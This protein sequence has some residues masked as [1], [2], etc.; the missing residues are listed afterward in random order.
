MNSLQNYHHLSGFLRN[1][2]EQSPG[3]HL[4]IQTSIIPANFIILGMLSPFIYPYAPA[5]LCAIG[6]TPHPSHLFIHGPADV[7]PGWGIR[8][9]S[10]FIH[11]AAVHWLTRP[12][13][14][15]GRSHLFILS[16]ARPRFGSS[17]PAG[18]SFIHPSLD[19][20]HHPRGAPPVSIYL[21]IRGSEAARASGAGHTCS[22]YSFILA[23]HIIKQV[24]QVTYAKLIHPGAGKSARTLEIRRKVLW[25]EGLGYHDNISIIMITLTVIMIT[26]PLS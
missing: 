18:I 12:W 7:W 15:G 4:F 17:S 10:Q 22:I 21:F 2:H 19:S 24:E 3:L 13:P 20:L 8:W 25:G 9:Q 14:C 23:T 26:N 11:P 1:Y 6:A 16:P 5:V